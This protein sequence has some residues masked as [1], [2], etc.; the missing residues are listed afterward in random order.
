MTQKK[1]LISIA[2]VALLTSV[3]GTAM[4]Q[5][6][7]PTG[8]NTT[9]KAQNQNT[10]TSSRPHNANKQTIAPVTNKY[11]N[12]IQLLVAKAN[13]NLPMDM[14]G[15]G[16]MV[17]EKYSVDNPYLVCRYTLNT[18]YYDMFKD[19]R[20]ILK[21]NGLQTISVSK[22]LNGE[23]MQLYEKLIEWGLGIKNVYTDKSDGR[24]FS[25]VLSPQEVKNAYGREVSVEEL[26]EIY[27]NQENEQMK[28]YGIALD[29]NKYMV[30]DSLEIRNDNVYFHVSITGG[31]FGYQLDQFKTDDGEKDMTGLVNGIFKDNVAMLAELK[32]FSEAGYGI[33]W[34]IKEKKNPENYH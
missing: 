12:E 24:Q 27:V 22:N 18:E 5:L 23:E 16:G 4:S 17:V 10:Q 20:E 3:C 26:A 9:R 28:P 31:V 11:S 8:F 29:Q 19:N 33:V 34:R 7:T 2:L 6:E 21:N 15:D 25:V 14:S 32:A 30:I 1:H 13:K